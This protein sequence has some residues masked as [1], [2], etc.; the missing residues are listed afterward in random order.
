[1]QCPV[2]TSDM[3]E[4]APFCAACGASLQR[5]CGNC[6]RPAAADAAFC[7]GCGTKLDNLE[8]A[9]HTIVEYFDVGRRVVTVVM[10]DLSGYTAM[11]EQLDAEEISA[12]MTRIKRE[13]TAIVE[14][15]GGV[16]N[17]F[18]G[19]EIVA[20]FG[21]PT[22]GEDDARRAVMAALALHDWV[23]RLNHVLDPAPP[24]PLSMHTGIY[25]GRLVLEQNDIRDGVYGITGDAINTAARVLGLAE[26]GQVL[27]GSTTYAAVAPYVVSEFAGAHSVRNKAEPIEVFRVLSVLDDVTRFDAAQARGLTRLTGRADELEVLEAALR[28]ALMGDPQ[29]VVVSAPAGTGKSRLAHEFA[30]RAVASAAARVVKGR[31]A[32]TSTASSYVPFHQVIRQL[33]GV[34]V[35]DDEGLADTVRSSTDHLG[36][37]HYAPAYLHLLS[38]L[39]STE[40]PADW[41]DDAL[42]DVLQRAVISLVVAA[43]ARAPL[44]LQLDD[45][46]WADPASDALLRRMVGELGEAR[47]VVQVSQRPVHEPLGVVNQTIELSPLGVEATSA[48]VAAWF[49]ADA[50]QPD[51]ATL[52]HERTLGNPFF[53]EEVCASLLGLGSITSSSGVVMILG[54]PHDLVIPDT[55]EAV[56]LSRVDALDVAT[57][58]V[59]RLASVIGREFSGALLGSLAGNQ[60][61]ERHLEALIDAGFVERLPD[62]GQLR[63]RHVITQEAVYESLLVRERRT[64][65][66]RIAELLESTRSAADIEQRREVEGLAL[67]HQRA[68]NHDRALD[69]FEQAGDKAAGSRSFVAARRLL[70]AAI[71]ASFELEQTAEVWARRGRITVKWASMCIF[72]PSANQFPLLEQAEREA[73]EDGHP[74][75]AVLARY[76]ICWIAYSIGDMTK[77]ERDTRALL[78]ALEARNARTSMLPM[79]RCHL[80]QVLYC[81]GRLD[82]AEEMLVSGLDPDLVSGVYEGQPRTGLECYSLAQ[83]A[84]VN[85]TRGYR[86][87]FERIMNIA[88]REVKRTRERGTEASLSSCTAVGLIFLGDWDGVVQAT[89]DIEQ[90]PEVS[91]S[92]YVRMVMRSMRSYGEFRL[93]GSA[94]ALRELEYVAAEHAQREEKLSLSLT[95]AL[96]ADA[97]MSVGRAAEA[98]AAAQAALARGVYDDRVGDRFAQSVLLGRPAH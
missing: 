40:L 80:G 68:G 53:V 44:V 28:E 30:A 76:W 22:A 58:S 72:I 60:P 66:A 10:S 73:I 16:A 34:G 56:V 75:T 61:I 83:L 39:A 85:A 86:S 41:A 94:A 32:A 50:V 93:T 89:H 88:K 17:Q 63:F 20:V 29:V 43:S 11:G 19:D 64:V 84:L 55:V 14:S 74:T 2:C 81:A 31:C 9:D 23:D 8:A 18:A 26:R 54:E 3:Q 24:V 6:G 98:E 82:E 21:V 25:T 12:I 48:M 51:L 70:R 1:M 79:L 36:I 87:E 69:Y 67:H 52:I 5:S 49:A 97:L 65:H 7:S 45:W 46:H 37:G 62:A 77:S 15:F 33:L 35:A 59:L 42:S 95:L 91:I 57:R 13:G 47:I 27:I 96:L 38:A 90:L 92:P 78:E 71:D 4:E